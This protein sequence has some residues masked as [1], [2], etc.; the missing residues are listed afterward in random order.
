MT[1]DHHSHQKRAFGTASASASL[2]QVHAN[3]TTLPGA[4]TSAPAPLFTAPGLA[5]SM[6]APR[7]ATLAMRIRIVQPS[8]TAA[9]R[10]EV[11]EPTAAMDTATNGTAAHAVVPLSQYMSHVDSSWP[12]PVQLLLQQLVQLPASIA[13]SVRAY[14]GDCIL[15]GPPPEPA[16]APAPEL[17]AGSLMVA[18][19]ASN[20]LFRA[21]A[22]DKPALAQL[23]L[24]TLQQNSL[25]QLPQRSHPVHNHVLAPLSALPMPGTGQSFAAAGS[26]AANG[27]SPHLIQDAAPRERSRSPRRTS[28]KKRR[29]DSS[30]ARSSHDDYG[31]R[32]SRDK[33]SRTST[34]RGRSRRRSRSPSDR[35]SKRAKSRSRSRS[36]R[37]RYSP[38]PHPPSSPR[39]DLSSRLPSGPGAVHVLEFRIRNVPASDERGAQRIASLFRI[40]GATTELHH[41]PRRLE[42]GIRLIVTTDQLPETVVARVLSRSGFVFNGRMLT[43]EPVDP[44]WQR[45][46]REVPLPEIYVILN[47]PPP[48]AVQTNALS[49]ELE[50]PGAWPFVDR[51]FAPVSGTSLFYGFLSVEQPRQP[52]MM[53]VHDGAVV[54][55]QKIRVVRLD[56]PVAFF[57]RIEHLFDKCMEI[58]LADPDLRPL[59]DRKGA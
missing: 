48:G 23:L 19:L 34:A 56:D 11:F 42:D 12:V 29:D 24:N 6:M 33:R 21:L 53:L 58:A 20:P 31:G 57:A 47:I 50:R 40:P 4:S 35:R 28:D 18:D 37:P 14:G 2:P 55:G 41:D 27:E 26:I 51:V 39:R 5:M 36:P 17:P 8:P 7:E 16:A 44:K 43:I 30:R 25:P 54:Y 10:V 13:N 38:R 49:R 52:N 46:A 45:M 1:S 22:Q 15:L 32:S 3:V 9:G 59:V